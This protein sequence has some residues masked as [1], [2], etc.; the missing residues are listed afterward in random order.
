MYHSS[1]KGEKPI[2]FEVKR[3]TIKVTGQGNLHLPTNSNLKLH[4]SITFYSGK[5]HIDFEVK[6]SKVK[7][8]AE[9]CLQGCFRWIT[10]VRLNKLFTNFT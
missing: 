9:D 4:I 7:V 2:D 8:T 6:R 10:P 5:T 1:L 3:S